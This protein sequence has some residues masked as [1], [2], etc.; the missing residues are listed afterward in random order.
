MKQRLPETSMVLVGALVFAINCLLFSYFFNADEQGYGDTIRGVVQ[1]R[2]I[3][4]RFDIVHELSEFDLNLIRFVQ[5]VCTAGLL[6]ALTASRLMD[7]NRLSLYLIWPYSA[8]LAVKLKQE[9]LLFP[10]AFIGLTKDW[11]K[12]CLISGA[13]LALTFALSENNGIIIVVFR[14][15]A[16][17][18]D[19]LPFKMRLIA[20]SAV[21]L[22]AFLADAYF[23]QFSKIVPF[24]ARYSYTRDIVNPEYSVVESVGVF[25]A[26][27]HLGINPQTD[28]PFHIPMSLISIAIGIYAL[29]FGNDTTQ[30]ERATAWRLSA[31]SG[32]IYLFFTGLTHAFQ[33]ARYFYFAVPILFPKLNAK[34]FLLL[35]VLSL[36]HTLLAILVYEN[37][38]PF[39]LRVQ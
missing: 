15:L 28:F 29:K 34:Q 21:A 8:F 5:V 25:L 7:L 2:A 13:I 14:V 17:V 38:L 39:N 9:F 24:L 19:R 33:N 20:I 10:L 22:V 23:E 35:L 37:S 1:Y 18:L 30:E 32:L 12:E 3:L 27:F 36:F 4:D 6:V 11:R 16:M 26:S 31:A